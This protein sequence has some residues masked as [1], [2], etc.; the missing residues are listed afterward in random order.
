MKKIAIW[1]LVL[2]FLCAGCVQ[3]SAGPKEQ[4]AGSF[5]DIT[6]STGRQVKI[7]AQVKSIICLNVGTLRFTTYMQATGLVV[8]VEKIEIQPV[9]SKPFNYINNKLFSSLPVIGDNGKTY[10]EEIIK[11]AP[12]VIMAAMDKEAADALQAKLKIPVVA[13]PLIDNMF[14]EKCY[15]TLALMGEVYGKEQRAAELTAYIKGLRGDLHNRTK[16]IKDKPTVYAAG[17]SFKGAH[18]FEGTEANYSPFLAIGAKNLADQTGQPGAFDVDLEQV[19]K[20]NP[21]IIFLD[22]NG[23]DL[24]NEHYAL[25]PDYYHSLSAVQNGRL[26]SQISFRSSAVN[27]E[28]ALA[29]AYY[30]GKV[31]FP[32]QFRDIDPAV[33]ADEIFEK[34]LGTKFYSTLQANGYEFR[35]MKL[36]E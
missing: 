17:I 21:D 3:E 29:D 14:D 32:E 18:G 2:A 16:N 23:M 20:W 5:R 34:M 25:N 30:A 24:I 35:Q 10:D 11:L 28:L 19:L 31:I 26:F 4:A 33:K 36:G 22:F 1:I 13:V 12:D 15:Q 8:G 27:A 6:D 9:I 7:P